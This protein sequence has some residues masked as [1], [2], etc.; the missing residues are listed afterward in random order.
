ME[1]WKGKPN[2]NSIANLAGKAGTIMY[3]YDGMEARIRR[4]TGPT[5]GVPFTVV[6]VNTV[7]T[8]MNVETRGNVRILTNN[9]LSLFGGGQSDG[10][11]MIMSNSNLSLV[12][13]TIKK[14]FI[15]AA[16]NITVSGGAF[17]GQMMAK[18]TVKIIGQKTTLNQDVLS[19][20]NF[21]LPSWK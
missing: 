9:A 8:S 14:G 16:N 3:V 11:L 5:S 10:K 4:I 6:I 18:G 13:W 17:T 2:Q 20:Q 21:W 12:G 1:D 15:S 19:D 7:P